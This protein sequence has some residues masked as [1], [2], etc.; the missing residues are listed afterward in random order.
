M[1]AYLANTDLVNYPVGIDFSTVDSA[2][3]DSF[4]EI[5]SEMVNNVTWRAFWDGP[6]TEEGQTIVDKEGRVFVAT[7]SK[8]IDSVTSLVF[9]IGSSA[10]ITANVS[11]IDLYKSAGYMYYSTLLNLEWG[12]PANMLSLADKVKYEIV[13]TCQSG[14]N[15]APWAVKLA[16]AMIARNLLKSQKN[17]ETSGI[18]GSNATAESFTSG[19]YTVN[20]WKWAAYSWENMVINDIITPEVYALLIPYRRVRQNTF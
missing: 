12:F 14:K 9:K 1:T 20:L 4:L 16:T 5:A 8:F 10:T 15:T 11:N 13:Y 3:L 2:V 6:H 19:D 18:T 7:K 17:Y